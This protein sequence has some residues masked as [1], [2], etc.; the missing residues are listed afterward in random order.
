MTT[1]ACSLLARNARSSTNA[2]GVV[3]ERRASSSRAARRAV[4][5]RHSATMRSRAL[6]PLRHALQIKPR[7]WALRAQRPRPAQLAFATEGAATRRRSS[8]TS[9]RLGRTPGRSAT[10]T[11]APRPAPLRAPP[12]SR[13]ELARNATLRL[14]LGM[15]SSSRMMARPAVRRR[16]AWRARA[17]RSRT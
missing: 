4:Q 3:R 14:I 2:A 17:Q 5:R 1:R 13:A 15:A 12:R 11:V 8:A 9:S 10:G 7:R 16:S 6:A